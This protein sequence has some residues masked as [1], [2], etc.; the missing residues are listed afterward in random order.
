MKQET[1]DPSE[2]LREILRSRGIAPERLALAIGI[3]RPAFYNV[4]CGSSK[5][6][7]ARQEITDIL[8]AKI[9][10]DIEIQRRPLLLWAGTQIESP[11]LASAKQTAREFAG[12]VTRHGKIVRFTKPYALL[13]ATRRIASTRTPEQRHI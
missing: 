6:R 2:K 5:N 1:T 10:N 4:S 11:T 7:R 12:F 13:M 8:Q 9:W 3:G